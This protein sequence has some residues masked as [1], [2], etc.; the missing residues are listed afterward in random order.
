MKRIPLTLEAD[1]LFTDPSRTI[2]RRGSGVSLYYKNPLAPKRAVYLLFAGEGVADAREWYARAPHWLQGMDGS[3]RVNQPDLVVRT[4][5]GAIRMQAQLD[6]AWRWI[7]REGGRGVL[8]E[9]ICTRGALDRVWMQLAYMRNPCDL[10]LKREREE[11]LFE[12]GVAR[13]SDYAFVRPSP[14]VATGWL[15]GA[16]LVRML[17]GEHEEVSVLSWPATAVADVDTSR[18]YRVAMARDDLWMTQAFETALSGTRAGKPVDPAVVRRMV[19]EG[20]AMRAG[21]GGREGE[22]IRKVK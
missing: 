19:L 12:A 6:T 4:Y 1:R 16:V 14:R 3:D 5:E 21:T 7:E 10:V 9:D 2:A 15:P 18:R 11:V 17:S 20:G 8:T 22:G 13:G